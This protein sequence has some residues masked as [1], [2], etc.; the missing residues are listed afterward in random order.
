MLLFL[1][2]ASSLLCKSCDLAVS[3][4][5]SVLT[6]LSSSR[7]GVVLQTAAINSAMF[8]IG[9]IITFGM[10]GMAIVVV[11]IYQAETAPEVLRG[12][13]G[14]TI[15]LMIITGSIVATCVT[16][17]TKGMDSDAGWRIP[18][19]LQLLMPALIFLLLPILPESPR[20]LLSQDRRD[21]ACK[22]LRKLR[23][24]ATEEEIQLEIEALQFAHA[25]EEKGTWAE[26]F[27]KTNRVSLLALTQPLSSS[28]TH[29]A[30]PCRSALVSPCSP[31]LGSR[32]LAR[33][34]QASMQSSSTNLRA[35]AT[36]PSSSISSRP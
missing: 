2:S 16:Y 26:V 9:R 35:L 11:P 25:N 28:Y 5:I 30:N 12:M 31:C 27:D 22:N 18:T 32:L 24:K 4:K 34:S 8:T 36:V 17:G 21:E 10:T 13:F 20:W 3:S 19:G 14:S 1:L 15:Q 7:S 29:H 33:L 23:K 6:S